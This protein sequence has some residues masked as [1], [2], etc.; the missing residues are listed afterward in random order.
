MHF[1]KNIIMTLILLILIGTVNATTYYLDAEK[2]ND[3]ADGTSAEPWQ[4]LAKAK[5]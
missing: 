5:S 4:T 1:K 3:S 2:G